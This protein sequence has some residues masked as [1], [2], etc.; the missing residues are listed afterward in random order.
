M[1]ATAVTFDI[2]L[3]NS[4]SPSASGARL[5]AAR[6]EKA[7]NSNGW[8]MKRRVLL[9]AALWLPLL[10]PTAAARAS[11]VTVYKSP[12][13]GCCSAWIA[14]LRDAGFDVKSRDVDQEPLWTLKARLGISPELS[15][16]HTA[17]VGGYF[18]EGHVPASDIDRLLK[19]RPEA[20]GLTVPGM[21]IGS[22]GMEMG[23]EREAFETL[24]VRRGV[25]PEVFTRHNR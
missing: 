17:L 11:E 3:R 16:C 9:L 6:F 8:K 23:N 21:P 18:V 14:H 12:T 24:L 7:R 22:P 5:G 25:R 4:A 1:S 13:C 15:S 20:L 10:G 2:V 19:E